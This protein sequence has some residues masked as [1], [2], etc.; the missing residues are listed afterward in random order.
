MTINPADV[1]ALLEEKPYHAQELV[2][3]FGVSA[4]V[5]RFT[6]KAMKRDGALKQIG[7]DQRWALASY[8]ASA[9][10]RPVLDRQA[11]RAAILVALAG[12]PL[13]TRIIVERSRFNRT[14]VKDELD[15][16]LQAGQIA[17]LG[18]ARWSQWALPS[19]TP[20]PPAPAKAARKAQAVIAVR[21]TL[22]GEGG[23][24]LYPKSTDAAGAPLRQA[25]PVNVPGDTPPSWW[26]GLS[27]DGLNAGIAVRAEAM[28]GSKENLRVQ[29]RILQ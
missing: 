19:W 12:G 1:L 28:R 5:V 26:V 18:A 23:R 24:R 17:H 13:P 8:V 11:C 14:A 15:A 9:G 2:E 29:L 3:A 22:L 10:R 21:D 16:L 20:P 25:K 4:D 7:T 6:L 27:R